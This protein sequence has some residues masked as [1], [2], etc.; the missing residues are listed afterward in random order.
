MAKR[1][2]IFC[3]KHGHETD[4]IAYACIVCGDTNR[5]CNHIAPANLTCRNEIRKIQRAYA[6]RGGRY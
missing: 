5:Q 3:M 2:R 6:K 4:W 1:K